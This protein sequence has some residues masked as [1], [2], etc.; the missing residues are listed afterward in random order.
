MQQNRQNAKEVQNQQARSPS[1][2]PALPHTAKPTNQVP[3]GKIKTHNSPLWKCQCS[4]YFTEHYG[5]GTHQAL[6]RYT[7]GPTCMRWFQLRPV[8]NPQMMCMNKFSIIHSRLT[9]L[10]YKFTWIM[11]SH[12]PPMAVLAE[13]FNSMFIPMA[14]IRWIPTANVFMNMQKAMRV[15][16]V[17]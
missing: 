10:C 6:F 9:W 1:K 5:T 17:S 15:G 12:F 7:D 2:P 16:Y 11:T 8:T 14:W 3:Q 4:S 13:L